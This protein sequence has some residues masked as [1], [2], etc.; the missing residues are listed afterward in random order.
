MK[1]LW[2]FVTRYGSPSSLG[3]GSDSGGGVPTNGELVDDNLADFEAID[4]N[5]TDFMLVED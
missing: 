2:Q 1:F 4:D 3:R 5:V